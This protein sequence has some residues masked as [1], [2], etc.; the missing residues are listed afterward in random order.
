MG[1]GAKQVL[2]IA[3][4]C[5]SLGMLIAPLCFSINTLWFCMVL[6]GMAQGPSLPACISY[7][8]KWIPP[9]EKSFAS[10]MID[11]SMAASALLVLPIVG[12]LASMAGWRACFF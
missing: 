5:G 6:I 10:A 12:I 8:A 4:G 3:N 7:A 2:T 9:D 11:S 1:F